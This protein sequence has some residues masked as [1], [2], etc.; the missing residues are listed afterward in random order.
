MPDSIDTAVNVHLDAVE[1]HDEIVFLYAVKAGPASQ[2]YGLQ[3]AALA[4]VPPPVI[5]RAKQH[6]IHLEQQ[7]ATEVAARPGSCPCSTARSPTRC[8]R[9]SPRSSRMR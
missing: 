2:S 4:G 9:P 6:L 3:V 7:A 5:Q 1:H 8:W